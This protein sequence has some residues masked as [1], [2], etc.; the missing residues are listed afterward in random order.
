[1]LKTIIKIMYS[2]DKMSKRQNIKFLAVQTRNIEFGYLFC[3]TFCSVERR[4]VNLT[5]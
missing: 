1:M 3:L 4:Y 5:L 2:Y